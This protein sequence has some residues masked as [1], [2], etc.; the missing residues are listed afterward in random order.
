MRIFVCAI[1]ITTIALIICAD[2]LA[3]QEIID[4]ADPIKTYSYAGG[5]FKY[6]DYTTKPLAGAFSETDYGIV[7]GVEDPFYD[8]L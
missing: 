2:A 8:L 4:V 1:G 7:T 6:I 3:E 5:G